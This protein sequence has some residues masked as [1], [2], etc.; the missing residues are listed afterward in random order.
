[1]LTRPQQGM[2]EANPYEVFEY[3][4]KQ[5]VTRHPKLSYLHFVEPR[6]WAP[7]S[8]ST[9]HHDQGVV[10]SND[11]VRTSLVWLFLC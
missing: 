10:P 5:L 6:E 8:A 1:M 9:G 3:V 4:T 7:G 2:G 11:R